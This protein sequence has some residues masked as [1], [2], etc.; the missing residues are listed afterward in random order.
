[1]GMMGLEGGYPKN[2]MEGEKSTLEESDHPVGSIKNRPN[3]RQRIVDQGKRG[4]LLRE[5]EL[6]HVQGWRPKRLLV[7]LFVGGT[8]GRGVVVVGEKGYRV[9]LKGKE[10]LGGF[11]VT[12]PSAD[13]G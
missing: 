1:M 11:L 3:I 2:C 9:E 5:E 8:R 13:W 4:D 6:G 10:V 7:H 12:P